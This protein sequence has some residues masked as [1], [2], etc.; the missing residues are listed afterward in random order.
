MTKKRDLGNIILSIAFVLCLLLLGVSATYA[1]FNKGLKSNGE[2]TSTNVTTGVLSVDFSTSKYINNINTQLIEDKNIFKEAD[3]TAFTIKR[4][5]LSTVDTTEYNIYLDIIKLPDALKSKH[6]KWALYNDANP[7]ENKNPL[8]TGNF[9]NIGDL[10]KIQLNQT[11]INLPKN[12]THEY[13]LYL[14]LSYSATDNQNEF[15]QQELH[16]KVE[17]EAYTY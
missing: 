16:V 5:E 7:D 8:S 3:K 13:T 14:W 1:Y 11:K 9:E 4:N 6:V 10:K 17:T 2:N 15:L 12:S